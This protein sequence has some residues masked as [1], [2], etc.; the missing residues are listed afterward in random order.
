MDPRKTKVC[1]ETQQRAKLL[2]LLEQC[3]QGFAKC[4]FKDNEIRP[5]PAGL[6]PLP[7]ALT[8]IKNDKAEV[9]DLLE[10]INLGTLDDPKP[11]FISILLFV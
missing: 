10:E 1:L 4:I 9:Q 7:K 2:F 6:S 11:L 8:K 3:S 5:P